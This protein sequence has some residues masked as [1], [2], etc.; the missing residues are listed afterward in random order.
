MQPIR[1]LV[2]DEGFIGSLHM[3]SGLSRAGCDVLLAGAV[4]GSSR[5]ANKFFRAI[6]CPMPSA[7]DFTD[8]VRRIS[9][10]FDPD[11]IYPATEY[12][13]SRLLLDPE[14][15]RLVFPA[16]EP[17]SALFDKVAMLSLAKRAGLDVPPAGS[18][19]RFPVVVKGH[20]GRGGDAVVIARNER[21]LGDTL[22][23]FA[24]AGETAY[25][26]H[27]LDAP[28]YLFGG[29]FSEGR[30]L[31]V[32]AGRKLRQYPHRTGPATVIRSERHEALMKAGL[33]LFEALRWTGL[34]SS[35]FIAGDD[36]RMY[37][38]DCNPRPWGSIAAARDAGVDLFT[39]LAALLRGEVP[40]PNLAFKDNVT[41]WVFPLFLRDRRFQLD[42]FT[43]MRVL[44][45]VRTSD[46][47]RDIGTIRHVAFRLRR[48]RSN[49]RHIGSSRASRV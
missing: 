3:A 16:I 10:A 35:D 24:R 44:R 20:C 39:P 47:W 46:L 7:P 13:M 41:S 11:V 14:L 48:V 33:R 32:Y 31:R 36:G 8:A 6:T 43:I 45:A 34:G 22:K 9:H 42:P 23:C 19:N 28:T 18:S 49:W 40:P 27:Y 30:A 21:H 37:F 5:C 26:Q 25:L 15:G 12:T 4:G 29:L 1:V 17:C 38:V 2:V